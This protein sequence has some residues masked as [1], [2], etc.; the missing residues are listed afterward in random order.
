MPCHLPSKKACQDE[1]Q[2]GEQV[3]E[4]GLDLLL[5]PGGIA[6]LQ[7]LK[8]EAGIV[9][10]DEGDLGVALRRLLEGPVQEDA[11]RVDAERQHQ[12]LP[13]R[14]QPLLVQG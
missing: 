9:V 8:A 2:L 11:D 10:V 5:R 4:R 13:Q 14:D 6:L 7:G 12:S 3:G 1:S